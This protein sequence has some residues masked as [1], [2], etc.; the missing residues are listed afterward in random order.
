MYEPPSCSANA[1]V[2]PFHIC[3]SDRPNFGFKLTSWSSGILE[4]TTL[5]LLEV[6]FLV[7]TVY[8]SWLTDGTVTGLKRAFVDTCSHLKNI[9]SLGPGV[10]GTVC[11]T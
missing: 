6:G 11:L 8:A 4:L 7:D 2:S 3:K 5:M 10:S 9:F 1:A